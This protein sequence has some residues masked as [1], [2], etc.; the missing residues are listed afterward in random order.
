MRSSIAIV[1]WLGSFIILGSSAAN[2][3][4]LRES[5]E[6]APGVKEFATLYRESGTWVFTVVEE[7]GSE[8]PE[9]VLH[10]EL[11]S[12]R[13]ALK[14]LKAWRSKR[15]ARP[16]FEFLDP[17]KLRGVRPTDRE[18]A[19]PL[20][21][22][23]E[24]WST[25]WELRYDAW[26]KES[27]HPRFF[28]DRGIATDCA[29]VAYAFRWIFAREHGLPAAN[30]LMGSGKLF[31]QDDVKSEW[32]KLP[33]AR[34][35]DKD[36]RFLAALN[37]VM[38]MTYTHVLS[39]DSFPVAL[40][41]EG[42]LR[43]THYLTLDSSSGHTRFVHWLSLSGSGSPIEYVESTVPRRVRVLV[44]TG[45]WINEQPKEG[46]GF[47]RF[48]WPVKASSGWKLTDKAEMPH[49]SLE[50]Y[51]PELMTGRTSFAEAVL[52]RLVPNLDFRARLTQG[53][54]DFKGLVLGRQEVVEQG[55]AHCGGGRCPE[56]SSN[57][58]AWSTPSRDSRV[59]SLFLQLERIV[60]GMGDKDPELRSIWNRSLDEIVFKLEGE[61]YTMAQL[62]LAFRYEL[63]SP[64]PSLS[65]A[66]RWALA[67]EAFSAAQ[68]DRVGQALASLTPDGAYAVFS[69]QE[70]KSD[71]AL[72]KLGA[73]LAIEA[74][75]RPLAK[76]E[77]AYLRDD[78]AY[79]AHLGED[80]K[81]SVMLYDGV[82]W[83]VYSQQAD[84]SQ[85]TVVLDGVAVAQTESNHQRLRSLDGARTWF[86]AHR[87]LINQVSVEPTTKRVE[88]AGTNFMLVEDG[89][90]LAVVHDVR[91][92]SS[93]VPML[94]GLATTQGYHYG[95]VDAAEL[96]G[97][98][99]K[100]PG[101]RMLWVDRLPG[102]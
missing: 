92:A 48:V 15:I 77:R 76:L 83:R 82:G 42:L 67:P 12:K 96:R 24:S 59:T 19:G 79:L 22:V 46:N 10:E 70:S 33:T 23:T 63:A 6:R 64:D 62:G 30:R 32:Q 73:G 98:V 54:E 9:L 86:E 90:G 99:V 17:A 7:R 57:Y 93:G 25:E 28:S 69:A 100:L 49:Y 91:A 94:T 38:K 61:T 75:E 60:N 26:V 11:T 1:L 21:K 27:V 47:M 102:G 14:R 101:E 80:E 8:L 56:G 16:A 89:I 58:E 50:Q 2:A 18:A 55:F 37:Y 84:E 52:L 44:E 29:D 5:R 95:Q 51:A 13:E 31:T 20:W 87:S 66:R 40:T 68:G 78:L 74:L 81:S 43:G 53:I 39:R 65:V 71:G 97:V 45:F 85:F 34:A 35:W 4:E 72:V 36:K 41:R 3:Q 88:F